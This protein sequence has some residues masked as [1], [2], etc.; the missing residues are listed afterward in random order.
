MDAPASSFSAVPP[1]ST[2]AERSVLGAMLQSGGAVSSALEMLS[3]D[4]FYVPA[5]REIFDGAKA[6]AVRHMAVDLVTMNSELSRRGTL[7]GVGGIEYLIELT[8]FVPTTV[9]VKDYIRIVSEKATLRRLI[10][11]SGEIS[12]STRRF[13]SRSVNPPV[14]SGLQSA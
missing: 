7:P 5:H 10:A 3:A 2:E 14:A 13:S 9:N 8:Q 12:T 6:L 1:H 11:A 4:D